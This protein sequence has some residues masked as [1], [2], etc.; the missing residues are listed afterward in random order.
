MV[1]EGTV[2]KDKKQKKARKGD[3]EE[4]D[5]EKYA[6]F[7]WLLSRLCHEARQENANTPKQTLKVRMCTIV[8]V[9]SLVQTL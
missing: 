7:D 8:A 3:V 4:E 6:S 5:G 1:T 2:M 9:Y